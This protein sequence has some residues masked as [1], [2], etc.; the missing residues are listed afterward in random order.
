MEALAAAGGA[1]GA[2]LD[3]PGLRRPKLLVF[4]QFLDALGISALASPAVLEVARRAHA[5][6]YPPHWTE[7]LDAASGALYFYHGLR[8]EASWQH[9]LAETMAEVLRLVH[10][11]VDERLNLGNLALRIEAELAGAQSRAA[12]ELADWVGPISGQSECDGCEDGVYFYNRCTG[13]SEWEDPRERWRFD[14]QVGYELLVG[15]LVAEERSVAMRFGTAQGAH[16][17]DLTPT[18]TSLA[19]TMTSVASLLTSSLTTPADAARE[20]AGCSEDAAAEAAGPSLWARPRPARRGG[21]PLPPRATF[22]AGH[23][24]DGGSSASNRAL[25]VMPPHQQRY[26]TD[27]LQQDQPTE[28]QRSRSSAAGV[29]GCLRANPPLPPPPPPPAGSPPRTGHTL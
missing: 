28:G 11:L 21:L 26:A 10:A 4:Q 18:L 7:E 2:L 5:M 6:P 19:S 13:A 3:W 25:F 17:P 14:L 8:D 20:V 27:I 12:E 15:F 1:P 29:F 24:A 16:S 23:C 9:P 22:S